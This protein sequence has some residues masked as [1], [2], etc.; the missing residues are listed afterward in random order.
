MAALLGRKINVQLR[1]MKVTLT[2]KGTHCKACKMLI[3]D[4]CKDHKEVSLCVVDFTTGKTEIEHNGLLDIN[5][6]TK[7]I[8]GLGEYKVEHA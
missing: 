4:V 8:E 3:E 2:I 1:S 6:L 5:A 7:E